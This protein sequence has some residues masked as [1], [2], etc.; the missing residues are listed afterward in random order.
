MNRHLELFWT[1]AKIGVCTFGGGYA[2][3]PILQRELVERK[4]WVTEDELTDYF[5]LGQCTPGVI[6]VNTATFTGYK[7]ADNWG[8]VVA[9]LGLCMPSV[10]VITIVAA[11]LSNFADIPAVGH[12]LA[13][14][15]AGVCAI[16]IPVVVRLTKNAVVDWPTGVIFV[17][18]VVLAAVWGLS[19]VIVVVLAGVCGYA[20]Q[21]MRGWK[22]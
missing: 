8:G 10:V 11:F 20:V 12:A 9:T 13:G 16:M 3:L 15:R 4:K 17:G 6:A 19:P 18:A 1:F 2:M 14:I 21:R 22:E 7:V 5:A